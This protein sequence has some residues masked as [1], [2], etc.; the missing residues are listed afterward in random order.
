[1]FERFTEEAR[2][3]VVLSQDEARTLGHNWIGTEHLLLGLLREGD[4][5]AAQVLAALGITLEGARENVV[6]VVGEAIAEPVAGMIP[7]TPRAKKVLEL[8]LREALSAGDNFIDTEHLLLGLIR[9]NKG[10]AAT[11]LV[12]LGSDAETIRQEIFRNASGQARVRRRRGGRGAPEPGAAPSPVRWQY[13][14]E[15]PELPD[16]LTAE[17]LNTLGAD[18]WELVAFGP[19]SELVFK[20]RLLGTPEPPTPDS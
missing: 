8:S 14:V 19:A 13:R 11:I 5:A 17:W 6:R 18:G 20:R 4:S 12:E 3:A 2:Q 16:G 9:E 7:F 10:L 15:R 1:M